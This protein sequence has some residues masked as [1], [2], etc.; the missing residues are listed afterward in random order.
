MLTERNGSLTAQFASPGRIALY[1]QQRCTDSKGSPSSGALD[2]EV[3]AD[4]RVLQED[5]KPDIVAEMSSLFIGG[6]PARLVGL[7]E[8]AEAGNAQAIVSG[9]H[10]LKG[11]CGVFGAHRMLALCDE[12][13]KRARAGDVA[14]AV[15]LAQLLSAEF[16]RVSAELES[17]CGA[18]FSR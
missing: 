1:Q 2:P 3:I 8:A 5:G 4:L 18:S 6:T 12:L 11:S 15:S 14:E 7:C 16:A 9:A 10:K 13:E 17:L